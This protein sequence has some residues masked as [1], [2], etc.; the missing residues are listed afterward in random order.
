MTA[1]SRP[2]F[3]PPPR[4]WSAHQLACRLGKGENWFSGHRAE[5]EKLGLPRF[6]KVLGGYDSAGDGAGGATL[7]LIQLDATP[8]ARRPGSLA[9]MG[10]GC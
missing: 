1:R 5:L 8:A 4:I 10:V 3:T 7:S 2:K 9:L 6:D